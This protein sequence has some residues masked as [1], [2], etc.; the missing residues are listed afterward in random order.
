MIH[1]EIAEMIEAALRLADE[2][3]YIR[4]DGE[5][6]DL[7]MTIVIGVGRGALSLRTM[8]ETHGV[9]DPRSTGGT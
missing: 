9:L 8:V 5:I 4:R 6:E 1:P 7:P 2:G 3:M